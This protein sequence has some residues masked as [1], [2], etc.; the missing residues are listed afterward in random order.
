L[1]P[2]CLVA[3]K[4]AFRDAW[5]RGQHCIIPGRGDLGAGWAQRALRVD[6]DRSRRRRANGDRWSVE[7]VEALGGGQDVHS[8]TMLT[9]NADTHPVMSQYHRPG[10]EKRMVVVL[11]EEDYDGWLDAPADRSMEFMRQ[12]APQDLVAERG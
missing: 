5:I 2:D 11:A 9:I 6:A 3:A 8:F 1:D 4:P 7:L 10:E 12:C